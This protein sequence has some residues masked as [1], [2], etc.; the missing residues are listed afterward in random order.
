MS[1]RSRSWLLAILVIAAGSRVAF[2]AEIAC[3][4]TMVQ[5]L[6]AGPQETG[7][8]A[9]EGE[10][11]SVTVVPLV[12][13]PGFDPE[14]RIADVHD[15]PVALS[16]GEHRCTGRCETAPLPDGGT[17]S[18]R[19]GDT[20]LGVGLYVITLEAVS[21]TANGLSN[22][23]PTPACARTVDGAPDGTRAVAAGESMSGVVDRPGETDTFTLD[24]TAGAVVHVALSRTG[25]DADFAPRW[26]AF[27]PAGRSIAAA[28][29][30]ETV[31]LASGGI[32]T[33]LVADAALR[34]TG[35]YALVV[36]L[37][38]ATTTTTTPPGATTTTGADESSTTSSTLGDGS[39]T[40]S[41]PDATT[42]TTSGGE[43]TTTSA[44]E[45]TS[46]I[47][48]ESTTST[49]ATTP[50]L[51]GGA[52]TT[53]LVPELDLETV[54]FAPPLGPRRGLGRVIAADG[55]RIA[56]GAPHDD[57]GH[58]ANRVR[59]AGVVL[60]VDVTGAPG[61]PTFGRVLRVT[62]PDAPATGDAF[63]AAVAPAGS[64][65][66]VAAP[67]ARLAFFF[68]N[69]QLGSATTFVPPAGDGDG[70]GAAIAVFG[71]VV[72]V[73][74][75]DA[76]SGTAYVFDRATGAPR[77]PLTA[78]GTPD[79]QRFGAALAV[80]AT[81]VL[82][83]AP[84]GAMLAGRAYVFDA[85]GT[86]VGPTITAN[87][88]GDEL[89]AAVAF[90]DDDPVVGAPGADG[91]AG[92]VCR[93]DSTTGAPIR[94]YVPPESVPG[95][96]FGAS[97]AIAPGELVVGA[98]GMTVDGVADAGVAYV[99]GVDTG[100]WLR[101]LR[102]PM[103]QKDDALGTAVAADDTYV[104][105]GTP[106][107]DAGTTD[108]G[109]TDVFA[110]DALIASLRERLTTEAFGSAAA[111]GDGAL[112]VGAPDGADGRG[113]VSRI[114]TGADEPSDD[115]V[116]PDARPDRFGASVAVLGQTVVIGAP[117][118]PSPAP[119]G[120]ERVGE[121][122]LYDGVTP[123][124]RIE[125]PAKPEFSAGDEF[126]FAVGTVDG[127]VL[128]SAPFA[129][130]NDTGLVY[131]VSP[132]TG[133]LIATY[134]KPVPTAGD[135]FGAAIA[136]DAGQV[137]V[138]APFDASGGSPIGAVYLF[139]AA[140]GAIVHAI[141]N[142]ADAK[143]LFGAS[144]SL[145]SWLVVGA[146]Q[147]NDAGG[148]V[149]AVWIFDRAS[150]AL[151][152]RVQNPRGHLDDSFGAAVAL[153]GDQLVVGAPLADDTVADAGLVYLF[154][155]STGQLLQT[156]RD[157]PQGAFDHFGFT[158]ATG[159][160]ALLVGSPGPSRVYFFDPIAHTAALMRVAAA[161]LAATPTSQCGNGLVEG[162]EQCDDGNAID[163]DDCRNDC[164]RGP[165]CALDDVARCDDG[166][167]CTTD[168][169]DPVI[170]CVYSPSHAPGCCY[171]DADCADGGVC[172]ICAGCFVYPWDCC[173]R[174]SHCVDG[175][176]PACVGK[177]CVEAAFCQCEGELA[178][179]GEDPVPDDVQT[180][181]GNACTPLQQLSSVQPDVNI[182]KD[183]LVVARRMARSARIA[184]RKTIRMARARS[185][186]GEMST[187]CRKLVV[188]KVR[189]L[190]AAIPHGKRLRRCL[191]TG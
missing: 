17:F 184:L 111:I 174:G 47:A 15:T 90:A 39:T 88:P 13:L 41:A 52:T 18:V 8:H 2:A 38:D 180:M 163:T 149:G 76:G 93:Y 69:V 14:W 108:G 131:R 53:T 118:S 129:G 60:V 178:C 73:G 157:P 85:A 142:P 177:T 63:G 179:D 30:D 130:P 72:I 116:S 79:G 91:G 102:K 65:L 83:G 107:D 68:P 132:Q 158:V 106:G 78:P 175:P 182:T 74:A 92:R 81:H 98:P 156:F 119:A 126:G 190:R 19:V 57:V 144:V 117:E 186:A 150:G 16:N 40:T 95:A 188:R 160:G 159:A 139:D 29:P 67:G 187:A 115:I 26:S 145:G 84:D 42:T 167:P 96:H 114:P 54:V 183:E 109:T 34:A 103:P 168:S 56:I 49:T 35:D 32:V 176:A 151:V 166:D 99:F 31:P 191:T 46:T 113:Y 173:D 135:F 146:P 181:F 50:T 136:G 171:G 189:A 66:A 128:A 125:N 127:D 48:G 162:D 123:T 134:G 138:G 11:V 170:G 62:R 97:I 155:A 148:L 164:T 45:T 20:G 23:P 25:G 110:G 112:Y 105:A 100:T 161:P 152:R 9:A 141:P 70:F 137:L 24:G 22:G 185:H 43:T 133:S 124:I 140:S 21:A 86:I 59:D 75:P 77:T 153:L 51:P 27:D 4:E 10:V 6:M 165:C 44:G 71:D 122:H 61:S 80:S 120:V 154:D 121:V 89:G 172:R 169:L 12:T 143:E 82:V 147:A 36:T 33:V 7:F 3:G 37:G 101:T 58:G 28:T 87:E 1:I 55:G 5:R 64:G 94:C 104:F